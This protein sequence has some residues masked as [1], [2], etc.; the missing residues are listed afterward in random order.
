MST[1]SAPEPRPTLLDPQTTDRLQRE[2]GVIKSLAVTSI[3]HG[4]THL[5]TLFH[6]IEMADELR[7]YHQIL[8]KQARHAGSR[9]GERFHQNRTDDAE[10]LR[11]YFVN[12]LDQAITRQPV[13]PVNQVITV[14]TFIGYEP[15]GG[16]ASEWH[17][18]TASNLETL[19]SLQAAYL[20]AMR[21]SA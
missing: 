3:A 19:A 4:D 17:A 11:L 21:R 2:E 18:P 9:N 14:T 8:T 1:T 20:N 6:A 5:E 7:E 13:T 12:L 10:Q 16:I 15:H